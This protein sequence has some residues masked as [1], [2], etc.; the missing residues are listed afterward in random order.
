MKYMYI[1]YIRKWPINFDTTIY[2]SL[3]IKSNI[4]Y[5]V[6]WMDENFVGFDFKQNW[7]SNT[8]GA[9]KQFNCYNKKKVHLLYIYLQIE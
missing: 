4:S 7:V 9:F 3:Q 8:S 2:Q 6:K 5:S 1:V